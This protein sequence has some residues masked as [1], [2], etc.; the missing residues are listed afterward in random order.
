MPFRTATSKSSSLRVPP[1]TGAVSSARRWVVSLVHDWDLP[2]VEDTVETLELLAGE[3]IANALVHAENGCQVTVCWD[4]TRVRL[5][6]EDGE[7][8]ALPQVAA[9]SLEDESGRGLQLIDGLAHAWGSR[10]TVD[11]K[12]VWFEVCS[13]SPSTYRASPAACEVDFLIQR[14]TAADSRCRAAESGLLSSSRAAVT[15]PLTT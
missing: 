11:G 8:G 6:A 5:E 12:A 1:D 9:A 4:G 15:R 13:G 10:P 7:T 14:R 2:L 3:V